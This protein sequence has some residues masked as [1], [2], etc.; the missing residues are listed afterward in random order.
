MEI[1]Q[2]QKKFSTKQLKFKVSLELKT[3]IGINAINLSN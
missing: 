1:F 3:Q 2:M